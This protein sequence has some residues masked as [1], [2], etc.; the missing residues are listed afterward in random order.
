MHRDIVITI[1]LDAIPLF[2]LIME[3][4]VGIYDPGLPII[5]HFLHERS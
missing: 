1:T 2:F 5:G 4:N 3:S